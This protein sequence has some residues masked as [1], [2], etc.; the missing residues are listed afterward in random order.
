MFSAFSSSL[1]DGIGSM[2]GSTISKLKDYSFRTMLNIYDGTFTNSNR[3]L[4]S[5][6]VHY[7]YLT[8]SQKFRAWTYLKLQ[9]CEL[10]NN[11]YMIDLTQI[12]NTDIFAFIAVLFFSVF[13]VFAFI[14]V[15][16]FQFLT[17]K[18]FYKVKDNRNC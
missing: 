11:K 15:L 1:H 5:N 17:R 9:S 2:R 10:Y 3:K 8:G 18:V 6:K 7:R 16:F 14:A 4:I 13:E 12:T